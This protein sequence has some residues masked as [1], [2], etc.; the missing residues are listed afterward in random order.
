MADGG[1]LN[2]CADVEHGTGRGCPAW[3]VD[4]RHDDMPDRAFWHHGTAHET[5][6]YGQACDL[7]TATVRADYYDKPPAELGTDPADLERPGVRFE[8]PG[9]DV[10]LSLTP[11]Q[12]RQLAAA[13]NLAADTADTVG[14]SRPASSP[15]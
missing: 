2:T 12:A 8:V 6:V 7:L 13:L 10:D 9:D 4:C 14:T 3:C 5:T 15:A 11:A 1:Q